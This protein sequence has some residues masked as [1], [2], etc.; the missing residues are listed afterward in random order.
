[1][2]LPHQQAVEGKTPVDINPMQGAIPEHK[3]CK[4]MTGVLAD[5]MSSY[6]ICQTDLHDRRQLLQERWLKR[7]ARRWAGQAVWNEILLVI[8]NLIEHTTEL[9]ALLSACP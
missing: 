3:H 6:M 2:L 8:I 4:N 5:S 9:W 1:M 7:P